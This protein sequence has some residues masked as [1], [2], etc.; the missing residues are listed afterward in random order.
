V[1]QGNPLFCPLPKDI[2]I[3]RKIFSDRVG[4]EVERSPG[5]F[6]TEYVSPRE[7]EKHLK[8]EKN[9][10]IHRSF[11]GNGNNGQGNG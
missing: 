9:H 3:K 4:T 5:E 10:D 1:S 6:G 11:T 8:K 2:E 7:T